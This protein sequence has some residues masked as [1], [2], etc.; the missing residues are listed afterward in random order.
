MLP[1]SNIHSHTTFAD[2]KNTAEEMA[3]AALA[4]GFHTLGFSEHGCA[5]YDDCAMPRRLEAAY[6]A[7]VLRLREAYRG[8]LA[9][10][11]GLEHDW[12]AAPP[13]DGYDYVIESVHYVPAGGGLFSVDDTPEL[14]RD[15]VVR[16]FGG[17]A[18][19]MCRAYFGQVCASCAAP[20]ATVLGH[21]DLVT[22]FNERAPLFDE[23]DP[24]YLACA[25]EAA[26]CEAESGR[27]VE[28]NTGAMSRGYRTSPYPEDRILERLGKA[29]KPVI[30]SS[31]AH[32]VNTITYGFEDAMRLVE[33]Y[34]LD[35]RTSLEERPGS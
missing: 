14:L 32:S 6:R 25:L 11:L 28:I 26:D 5:P 10:L 2:G 24:R 21:I 29:G 27:L 18:Y 30:L 23:A 1:K 15:A 16:H 31:D 8:R 4:L 34:G 13:D 20:W 3:R 19:A 22:K 17:D 12:L 35:L 33:R 9:I 7:E